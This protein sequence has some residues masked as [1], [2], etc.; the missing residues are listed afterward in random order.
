[1]GYTYD[2][3]RVRGDLFNER[4]KWK[5]TVVLDYRGGDY[6]TW[7]LW[8]EARNALA[9]ATRSGVSGVSLKDIPY[10]WTLVVLEPYSRNGHPI[11]VEAGS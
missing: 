10:G 3:S 7:D 2:D 8:S 1:M 4:G 6:W 9:R 5:Y 11:I